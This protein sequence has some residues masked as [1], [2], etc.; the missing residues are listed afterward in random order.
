MKQDT[1]KDRAARSANEP[2]DIQVITSSTHSR[3]Q[4]PTWPKWSPTSPSGREQNSDAI[5]TS[6]RT[7]HTAHRTPHNSRK[8]APTSGAAVA[9]ADSTSKISKSWGNIHK[10][11]KSATSFRTLARHIHRLIGF[12]TPKKTPVTSAL[13]ARPV[14]HSMTSTTDVTSQHIVANKSMGQLACEVKRRTTRI[15]NQ[16][17]V[18]VQASNSTTQTEAS[19]SSRTRSQR[20]ALRSSDCDRIDKA[21]VS[22]YE[23]GK[24]AP[25]RRQ[26]A[27]PGRLVTNLYD[28]KRREWQKGPRI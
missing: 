3:C 2:H 18:T 24:P 22:Y 10:T 4:C 25:Q 14:G 8:H 1:L 9:N 7:P 5:Q 21:C 28:L 19:T 15:T 17:D 13:R 20:Q 12:V 27:Y 11:S 23:Q 6:L 26:R 16:R